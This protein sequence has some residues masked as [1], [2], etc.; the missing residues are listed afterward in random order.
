MILLKALHYLILF[1]SK[2]SVK[3]GE[4][5]KKG[6]PIEVLPMAYIPIINKIKEEFGGEIKLRMAVAKAV[7]FM[8]MVVVSN[9]AII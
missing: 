2:D 4:K 7:S 1:S 5:Y 6:L 3:L 8:F 9:L